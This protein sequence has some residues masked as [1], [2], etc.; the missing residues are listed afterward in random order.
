MNIEAYLKH[1]LFP[2]LSIYIHKNEKF[3]FLIESLCVTRD[4][5]FQQD[6]S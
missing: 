2:I 5:A 3:L 1:P 4:R 6:Y